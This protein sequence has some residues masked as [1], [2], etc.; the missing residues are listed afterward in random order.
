MYANLIGDMQREEIQQMIRHNSD[1]RL[2]SNALILE[3][4]KSELGQMMEYN[5][6]FNGSDHQVFLIE[7]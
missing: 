6:T 4:D 2:T 3:K 7:Q 5:P 1:G